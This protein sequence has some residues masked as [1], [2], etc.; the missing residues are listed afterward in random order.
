MIQIQ[1]T[2]SLECNY[3]TKKVGYIITLVNIKGT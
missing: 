3:F 1:S 2:K